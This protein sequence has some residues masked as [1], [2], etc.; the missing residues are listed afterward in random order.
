[1]VELRIGRDFGTKKYMIE[2]W[3]G[4]R[5]A[6]LIHSSDNGVNISSRKPISVETNQDKTEVYLQFELL[7]RMCFN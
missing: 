4:G 3:D 6:A 2:V 5:I 7:D 1:M